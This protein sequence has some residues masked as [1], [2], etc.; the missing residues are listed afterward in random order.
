MASDDCRDY[1]AFLG[2]RAESESFASVLCKIG[3][4]D[5]ACNTLDNL[6]A[7]TKLPLYQLMLVKNY[8]SSTKEAGASDTDLHQDF[9]DFVIGVGRWHA[10][11][12]KLSGA[13]G[14]G[15]VLN[16][17]KTQ[18][19]RILTT[20]DHAFVGN[21]KGNKFFKALNL[22]SNYPFF[23]A[24][25]RS[26]VCVTI[27][28]LTGDGKPENSD[29]EKK[30]CETMAGTMYDSSS[31]NTFFDGNGPTPTHEL[32]KLLLKLAGKA[33]NPGPNFMTD[34]LSA[35]G[36]NAAP[37]CIKQDDIKNRFV[38]AF[39]SFFQSN[40]TTVMDRMI[41]EYLE[42]VV[43]QPGKYK[44][45]A[46]MDEV[47]A[48]PL[49][50]KL[51]KELD[52][53]NAL[54][55][56]SQTIYSKF[57]TTVSKCVSAAGVSAAHPTLEEDEA[58]NF[59]TRV[60]SLWQSAVPAVKE[61]YK[62]NVNIATK[63][64]SDTKWVFHELESMQNVYLEAATQA[65]LVG[66]DRKQF[67]I[68]LKK[69]PL[70]SET[71][72][73][74][75]K[76]PF[77]PS[78]IKKVWYTN[79][80][81]TRS[82]LTATPQ[83]LKQLYHAAF[84]GDDSSLKLPAPLPKSHNDPNNGFRIVNPAFIRNY[85]QDSVVDE[86][87]VQLTAQDLGSLFM[88]TTSGAVYQRDEAGLYKVI[89]GERK[90]YNFNDVDK[91]NDTCFGTH[92]NAKNA[93]MN[94][95]QCVQFVR[96]CLIGDCENLPAVLTRLQNKDL[97]KEAHKECQNVDPTIALRILRR[98]CF[99]QRDNEH[100]LAEVESYEHWENRYLMSAE[101]KGLREV[102][103][104]NTELSQY[105]KGIIDFVNSNPAILNKKTA[106]SSDQPFKYTDNNMGSL[107]IN[108]YVEP[109][110]G[111]PGAA[112]FAAQQMRNTLFLQPPPVPSLN[113]LVGVAANTL[114]NPG[115]FYPATSVLTGGGNVIF[116]S[117]LNRYNEDVAKG[118]V[119]NSTALRLVFDETISILD[120]HGYKLSANSRAKIKG[121]L[122]KLE[123]SEKRLRSVH[124]LLAKF[125]ALVQFFGSS[126]C[127]PSGSTHDVSLECLHNK[128]QSIEWLYNNMNGM[129]TCLSNNIV[130]QNNHAKS[131]VDKFTHLIESAAGKHDPCHVRTC[132]PDNSGYV[133]LQDPPKGCPPKPACPN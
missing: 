103:K 86:E 37:D 113:S 49:V 84:T 4:A 93:N 81:R 29:D 9:T 1:G 42:S 13:S 44:L 85:I 38:E 102:L 82:Q 112:L 7:V 66:P 64:A 65:A 34:A 80:N 133:Q 98:F 123:T 15:A 43:G 61:F 26:F 27:L 25:V 71:T 70:N 52:T 2:C 131:L 90:N 115:P 33:V 11:I 30:F 118:S 17:Y 41:N 132:P 99:K 91:N 58:R 50:E 59:I 119:Q 5:E 97:F 72:V 21:A 40:L 60:R 101:S 18:I 127:V 128:K 62:A 104:E 111:T 75:S 77:I 78:S 129:Y 106:V 110:R 45:K 95:D 23:K 31:I 94:N 96:E 122:D 35:L 88:D 124:M 87:K 89:N 69:F 116:A 12:D 74:E 10:L 100:G 55:G 19:H 79:A 14:A 117:S 48:A 125:S 120:A 51:A 105:L 8:D 67:R 22:N 109:L 53:D 16:E 47:K 76:L 107:K 28:M 24:L 108:Y 56:L 121:E 92:L 3:R 20:Q 114:I 39:A 6:D 46:G 54:N 130:A 36:G 83:T 73:F 57:E 126:G 68:N 32:L 63:A